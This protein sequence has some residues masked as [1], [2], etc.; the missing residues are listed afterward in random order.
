MNR[1]VCGCPLREDEG[2][3]C[4]ACVRSFTEAGWIPPPETDPEGTARA[5]LL[6]A[7]AWEPQVRIIGNI[8]ADA[9]VA[10]ARHVLGEPER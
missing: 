8:R 6:A 9:L 3:F 4:S 1:C 5:L 10:L 2:R 7:G